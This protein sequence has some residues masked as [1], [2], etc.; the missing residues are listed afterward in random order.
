MSNLNQTFRFWIRQRIQQSLDR[1][2]NITP[3][4]IWCD[5]Q[6]LW[7]RLLEMASNGGAFE[8]WVGEEHELLIRQRFY[9]EPQ[10]PRVI[11]LPVSQDKMSYIKIIALQAAEIV[12]I[13]LA[14]A[15]SQFG[16]GV[17]L[18][19]R[20]EIEPL[21]PVH[22]RQWIDYPLSHWR[23]NLSQGQVK[24]S[25]LDDQAFLTILASDNWPADE[26]LTPEMAAIFNRRAVEDFG[27]P[28]LV[29]DAIPSDLASIDIDAWRRKALASLLVTEAQAASPLQPPGDQDRVIQSNAQRDKALKL[30]AQWQKQVDLI[31]SF[32]ILAQQA[33]R[34]TSLQFWAR[35]L[36]ALPKPLS[37]P[38]VENTL[39][40]ATLETLAKISTYDELVEA[41]EQHKDEYQ[42]HA[43]SFW[44]AHAR[45]RVRWDLLYE[46]SEVA[47]LL[48]GQLKVENNWQ[49]P[50]DAVTW[51]TQS[52]WQVDRAGEILFQ[53]NNSMPGALI[54]VRARLR[55]AYQRHV[56]QKNSVF[57]DLLA[58]F[59]AGASAG[60]PLK[61]AGEQ[62]FQAIQANPR[63]P[64]AVIVLDACRYDV[65]CR[66]AESINQGEPAQRAEVSPARAPLPSITPLGMPLG[67]P[68]ESQ[69]IKVGL[70]SNPQQ[71][72]VVAVDGF[73][74]NLAEA[75]QR[76]EWLRQTYKVKENG[77]LSVS[78]VLDAQGLE[79]LSVRSSGRLIFVFGDELDD[80]DGA[81]R[82]F[83]L[84][85]TIERYASLVRRLRTAGYTTIYVVAD[86]GFFRWDPDPDEKDVPKPDG[87]LLWKSR[88]AI[89]GRDLV[90]PTAI[91][92]TVTNSDL[93]CCL[94]RSVNSFKTYGGLGFFHGGAT[95]QELV[96]PFVTIRWPQ[97]AQKIGG[98]IKPIEQITSLAQ[99]VQVGPEATQIGLFQQV[100]ENLL[101]RKVLLKVLDPQTGKLLF[102]S[103][104][105]AS[106]EPGGTVVV[107]ELRN[108][109]GAKAALGSNLDLILIDEDD[110]E[111][112][113]RRGVTLQ[114][115]LDEWI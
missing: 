17:P 37:S 71:P 94:P 112:L 33:D 64:S 24:S 48:H 92:T 38:I 57:A 78:Q 7:G 40:Q 5:P 97:K 61:F 113:D 31:E 110:E 68:V 87:E 3:L 89:V 39:F 70:G 11:W 77:L 25:L 13:S 10:A 96:V 21:L 34:M 46:L 72:W 91:T 69:R 74:G 56:D 58:N 44:G 43:V 84:E 103:T 53:E 59:Q 108:V 85:P 4:V 114:V 99:R 42:A 30:L 22:A 109:P 73:A 65:G 54:G 63:Q 6:R 19:Q 104:Q 115:E 102:K 60:L 9:S 41:L 16:V 66:L 82:P 45:Q 93:E 83:G 86:H 76:R 101:S 36:N 98:V 81:L 106:I 47:S 55:R 88:R 26:L 95:L 62:L 79:D 80:H 35:N 18:D 8:L 1:R 111:I 107:M 100:D 105:P 12:E 50:Q 51:Y 27:L 32:E 49:F 23:A 67:L 15:L 29:D 20:A 52:G 75:A 2:S 90:H 28:P 14:E